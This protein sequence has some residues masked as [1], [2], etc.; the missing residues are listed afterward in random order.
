MHFG[1]AAVSWGRVKGTTEWWSNATA[2]TWDPLGLKHDIKDPW[3]PIFEDHQH[4]SAPFVRCLV[5]SVQ[6]QSYC[7]WCL[8]HQRVKIWWLNFRRRSQRC[9]NARFLTTRF[10]FASFA[11]SPAA[12]ACDWLWGW[13]WLYSHTCSILCTES[14]FIILLKWSKSMMYE[15]LCPYSLVL[16][17]LVISCFFF[18]LSAISMVLHHSGPSRSQIQWWVNGP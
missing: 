5:N 16:E 8:G 6:T 14:G 4:T 3:Y 11:Q 13:S 12:V 17:I 1:Q 18:S 9:G 10:S 2:M 7:L 15:Y